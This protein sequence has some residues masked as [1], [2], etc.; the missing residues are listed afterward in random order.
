MER[1]S[2]ARF[3]PKYLTFHEGGETAE[4]E[5]GAGA[6]PDAEGASPWKADDV[7]IFKR[8][9]QNA[10]VPL[11]RASLPRMDAGWMSDNIDETITDYVRMEM[12]FGV[13]LES[14]DSAEGRPHLMSPPWARDLFLVVADAM[15][16]ASPDVLVIPNS[17]T[18]GDVVLTRAARWA[19]GS[20]GVKIVM[21]FP[22]LQ[23]AQGLDIDVLATPSH[24]VARHPDIEALAASTSARVVVI[25]PG[26]EIA[27]PVILPAE[28]GASNA[29]LSK[30]RSGGSMHDLQC[31]RDVPTEVGCRDPDG[32]MRR[33]TAVCNVLNMFVWSGLNRLVVPYVPLVR[34]VHLFSSLLFSSLSA[35][36][37]APTLVSPSQRW[38]ASQA[39]LRTRKV[40]V[41]F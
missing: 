17:V 16:R 31:G 26:I 7:D 21:D 40:L 41:C 10:D 23:P 12:G 4:E 28:E 3:A 20:R 18:L 39:A 5:E 35:C 36:F 22:N 9:L 29:P 38:L 25:P 8:R 37:P 24:Y 1:L 27:S 14:I 30:Y 2:R 19:M 15:K 11:V 34:R 13:V 33:A 6:K 32:H